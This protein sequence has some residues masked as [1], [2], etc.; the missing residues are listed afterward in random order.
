MVSGKGSVDSATQLP[1]QCN[2]CSVHSRSISNQLHELGEVTSMS[3]RT[4]IVPVMEIMAVAEQCSKQST[5]DELPV[6]WICLDTDKANDELMNPC[7]CPRYVHS[8]CLARWQVGHSL[9]AREARG[10]YFLHC[11]VQFWI[12]I[13]F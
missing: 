10:P 8:R 2:N 5:T 1:S 12:F 4:S 6:C 3:C 7:A 11:E 9:H 13:Q